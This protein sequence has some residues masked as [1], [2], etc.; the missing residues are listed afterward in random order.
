MYATI[1]KL[2]THPIVRYLC[3]VAGGAALCWFVHPRVVSVPGPTVT[4]RVN[5]QGPTQT[6]T[7]RESIEYRYVQIPSPQKGCPDVTVPSPIV[8]SNDR[9]TSTGG[10]TTVDTHYDSGQPARSVTESRSTWRI[11]ALIGAS[12]EGLEVGGYAAKRL[13]GPID[14]G[15]YARAPLATPAH[16]SVGLTLGVQW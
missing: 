16:T 1:L 11:G 10:T 8:T 14:V 4:E 6:C 15:I 12:G 13:L 2:A 9:S 7:S 5:V 3:A